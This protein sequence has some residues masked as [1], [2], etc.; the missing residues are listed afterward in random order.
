MPLTENS[1]ASGLVSYL[2]KAVGWAMWLPGVS[3]QAY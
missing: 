3:G 1:R 2:S